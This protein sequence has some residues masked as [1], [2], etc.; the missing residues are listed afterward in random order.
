MI[1]LDNAAT[2]YIK[3]EVLEEMYPYF[4]KNFGNASSPYHLGRKSK[5]AI[6]ASRNKVADALKRGK[7]LLNI[8]TQIPKI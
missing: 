5:E 4:I 2:T 7:I 1:Y 8:L 6:E 3:K